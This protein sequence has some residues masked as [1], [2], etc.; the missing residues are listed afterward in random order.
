MVESSDTI[1]CIVIKDRGFL[2]C[3]EYRKLLDELSNSQLL[4]LQ[5]EVSYELCH[6]LHRGKRS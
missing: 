1:C 4:E 2:M 3:G 5:R 6:R